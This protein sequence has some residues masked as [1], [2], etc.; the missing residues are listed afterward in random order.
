MSRLWMTIAAGV[1][2]STASIG[3]ARAQDAGPPLPPLPRRILQELLSDPQ[4]WEQFRAEHSAVPPAPPAEQEQPPGGQKPPAAPL[5]WRNTPWNLE[6]S[7]PVLLTDGTVMAHVSCTTAWY[8]LTPDAN[9]DYI[10]GTWRKTAPL[11]AGYAPRFFSSAILSDGRLIIEGGEYNGAACKD[12]ET[13]LGAI[14]DPRADTWTPAPAPTGWKEIG[15]ASGIVL[16]NGKY[17]LSNV[18][19]TKLA[20][21]DPATLTWTVTNPSKAD[22]SNNEE[23]W[24][25]LPNGFVLTVE[26]YTIAPPC[27]DGSEVFEPLTGTWRNA[28]NT[29][30]KLELAQRYDLK[31]RGADADLEPR[32]NRLRLQRLGKHGGSGFPDLYRA[33]RHVGGDLGGRTEDAGRRRRLLRHGRRAGGDLAGRFGPGRD[34]PRGLDQFLDQGLPRADPFLHLQRISIH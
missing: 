18:D 22:D 10:A 4:K 26:A 6:L 15:D 11:P 24:T 5:A 27:G 7:N 9:G 34:E 19:N 33:L 17:L 23:N 31:L 25:L 12:V 28:G 30:R 2:L 3:A 8:R 14:Y 13:N 1:A 29:V 16:G 32:W 21:L 20:T